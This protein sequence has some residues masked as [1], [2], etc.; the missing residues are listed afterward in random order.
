MSDCAG[1][2]DPTKPCDRETLRRFAA[3]CHQ[4]GLS[5]DEVSAIMLLKMLLDA[6]DAKRTAEAILDIIRHTFADYREMIL[7][8]IEQKYGIKVSK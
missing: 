3:A 4:D 7:D 6:I 2:D 8:Q 5:I 1:H